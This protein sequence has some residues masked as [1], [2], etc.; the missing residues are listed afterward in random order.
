MTNIFTSDQAIKAIEEDPSVIFDLVRSDNDELLNHMLDEEL[1]DINIIS[2]NKDSLAI[3]LL[4]HA[5]YDLVL[6]V[7]ENKD[8]DVNYQN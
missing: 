7:I 2:S 1:V 5:K 4:K 6:K 3:K 8:W